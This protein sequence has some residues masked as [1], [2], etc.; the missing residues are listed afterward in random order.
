MFPANMG[1]LCAFLA[2]LGIL[3]ISNSHSAVACILVPS[4]CVDFNPFLFVFPIYTDYLYINNMWWFRYLQSCLWLLLVLVGCVLW[5]ESTYCYQLS[6]YNTPLHFTY[7]WASC[8]HI[9]PMGYHELPPIY[10]RFPFLCMCHCYVRD[11]HSIHVTNSNFLYPVY[12][13]CS[14]TLTIASFMLHG[15]FH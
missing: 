3:S 11:Q 13:F 9:L 1:N 2:L 7:Y 8:M 6:Y 5:F 10:G 14:P 15:L 12:A 4:G